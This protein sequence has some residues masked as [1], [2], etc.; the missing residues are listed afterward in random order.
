MRQNDDHRPARFTKP[1]ALRHFAGDRPVAVV[2]DDDPAVCAA[3]AAAGYPVRRAD[4]A[5][6]PASLDVAQEQAGRT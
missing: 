4:W 1:A 6:R 2:V 3:F 5:D